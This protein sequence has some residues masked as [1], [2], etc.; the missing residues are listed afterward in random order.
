MV[1]PQL[2]GGTIA[3]GLVVCLSAALAVWWTGRLAQTLAGGAAGVLAAVALASVPVMLFQSMQPM[4]DVPVTAA[5]LA[6]WWWVYQ[7]GEDATDRGSRRA[8]VAGVAAGIAVLV[9][10]NLAPLAAVPALYLWRRRSR[11][12][13]RRLIAFAIPVALA[14]IAIAWLQWHWFG[15]PLRSGYGTAAE[16][17]STHNIGTNLRLYS[18]WLFETS[19]GWLLLGGAGVFLPARPALAWLLA[20]AG[21]VVFAYLIYGPFEAWPYLR[22][23][24]PA[25]AM[26]CVG[27]AA[28]V[29]FV[30]RRLPATW[31]FPLLFGLM[32]AVGALQI[33][34]AREIGVFRVASSHARAVLA[35]HYLGA[36][37]PVNAV[38]LTGEQSGAMRYYTGRTIVRWD[39][40]VAEE[41]PL[42]AERLQES[43]YELW[44]VLDDWE[45]ALFRDK[46]RSLPSGALDWPPSAE[47]RGIGRTQVWR[48]QDRAPFMTGSRVVTDWLR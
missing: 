15:S 18:G 43:K 41:L 37:A 45:V 27:A 25:V 3:S 8:L 22:F 31:Q 47:A 24:L 30:V 48:L 2:V 7:S 11:S 36:A 33:A 39:F 21:L 28:V 16:I 40:L 32:L 35:G 46:F 26:L 5:W 13:A 34:R 23:V 44:I 1:F 9:R 10:P 20:F 19:G 6:T 42:V 17:Y 29:G 12:G 4:S 38:L 14:G